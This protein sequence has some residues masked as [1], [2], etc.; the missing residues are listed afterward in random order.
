[1]KGISVV[2]EQKTQSFKK[3][4]SKSSKSKKESILKTDAPVFQEKPEKMIAVLCITDTRDVKV[5]GLKKQ[6]E[7]G[8]TQRD[9][10]SGCDGEGEQT[11][12]EL[13]LDFEGGSQYLVV[14]ED[15]NGK[16]VF[17]FR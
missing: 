16:A 7:V 17:K 14:E 15:E 4:N 11:Y 9:A 12:A 3:V 5:R 2:K 13:E 10:G 1:M 8:V 6:S